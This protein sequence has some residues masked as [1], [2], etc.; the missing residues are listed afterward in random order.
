MNL[1]KLYIMSIKDRSLVFHDRYCEDHFV[2]MSGALHTE[3][4]AKHTKWAC[5]DESGWTSALSKANIASQGTVDS[6]LKD[7]NVS[8]TRYSHEVKVCCIFILMAK[9]YKE[10]ILDLS[11][12]Q[13]AQ[14]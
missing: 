7:S 9:A 12:D 11:T 13:L 1:D 3:V 6:L 4:A 5:L 14:I 10:D 8:R 2:M